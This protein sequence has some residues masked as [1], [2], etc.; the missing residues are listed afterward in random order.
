VILHREDIINRRGAFWRLRDPQVA[1]AFD[2]DLLDLIARA[3]FKVV[4]V[5]IDKLRLRERYTTPGHPYHLAL[6]F[7]L[8]RYCGYLNHINRFGD[9]LAEARGKKEDLLLRDSY[10]WVY[11]RGTWGLM[12]AQAFQRALTSEQLKLKPKGANVAGLQLA[13]LLGHPIKQA[14]LAENG[15]EVPYPSAFASGMLA[16]AEAKFNRHLYKGTIEGYGKILFPK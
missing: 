3:K 15:V 12:A 6:G 4:A 8:Q 14:T 5:V 7:L 2:A 13:D 11:H 16:V 1:G 9:V 10:S